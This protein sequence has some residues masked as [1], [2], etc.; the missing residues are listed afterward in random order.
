MVLVH[1]T[2]T[3]GALQPYEVSTNSFNSVQLTE[4]A[5]IAFTYVPRG[6]I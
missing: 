6:I 2:S 4:R 3:H 1:D 5:E